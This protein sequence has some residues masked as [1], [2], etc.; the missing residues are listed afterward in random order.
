MEIYSNEYPEIEHEDDCAFGKDSFGGSQVD[1]YKLTLESHNPPKAPSSVESFD[2]VIDLTQPT[3]DEEISEIPDEIDPRSHSSDSIKSII[4]NTPSSGA[5]DMPELEAS[6][7][8]E[9]SEPEIEKEPPRVR[10]NLIIPT[11]AVVCDGD[12][13]GDFP[14]DG[15][16]SVRVQPPTPRATSP[17]KGIVQPKN[18]YTAADELQ[19]KMERQLAHAM[20]KQE[21]A[22]EEEPAKSTEE[23]DGFEEIIEKPEN[24][25]AGFDEE[26]LAKLAD[27]IAHDLVVDCLS[28]ITKQSIS[29]AQYNKDVEIKFDEKCEAK[30]DQHFDEKLDEK[31]D[32][33]Y[34]E[35]FDQ[36]MKKFTQEKRFIF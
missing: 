5:A 9:K 31:Y 28:D 10:P 17:D 20:D 11:I 25:P 12:E 3:E 4:E 15:F 18:A 21:P 8:E 29:D 30:F 13:E 23:P 2:T 36:N 7:P 35:K 26:T 24:E 22:E 14:S 32:E 33:R 34:D 1:L 16:I 19:A 27:I 6:E